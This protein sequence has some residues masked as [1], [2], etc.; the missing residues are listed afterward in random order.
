MDLPALAAPVA[1]QHF[2]DLGGE[3]LSDRL[4]DMISALRWE[5]AFRSL[6][7]L[8][9]ARPARERV[10]LRARRVAARDPADWVPATQRD[11][12]PAHPVGTSSPGAK[13]AR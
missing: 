3:W 5:R 6:E 10:K 12:L 9:G 8:T 1:V 11:S 2:H 4:A 7:K 13:L